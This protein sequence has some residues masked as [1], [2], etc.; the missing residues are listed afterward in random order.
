MAACACVY[1][2]QSTAGDPS[3]P[4]LHGPPT[5]PWLHLAVCTPHCTGLLHVCVCMCV[6]VCARVRALVLLCWRNRLTFHTVFD[7][8]LCII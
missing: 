1:V 5:E 3:T 7:S 2:C 8:S 6:C 4:P